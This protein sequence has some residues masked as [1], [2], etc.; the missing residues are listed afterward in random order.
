MV[1]TNIQILDYMN[2]KKSLMILII[3]N[4][5]ICF[6][7]TLISDSHTG[8][9]MRMDYDK[10]YLE[11]TN[12]GIG[13]PADMSDLRVGDKIIQINGQNVSELSDPEEFLKN[14][15]DQW[16][17]LSIKR[18]GIKDSLILNVPR[19]SIDLN[20]GNYWTEGNLFISLDIRQKAVKMP[21][22]YDLEKNK[23]E[24]IAIINDT[25]DPSLY[26]V[27]D[28][29]GGAGCDY[30]LMADCWQNGII[31]MLSDDSRNMELYKTFDFDFLS[32]DDPLMEKRL[33]A[34]LEARLTTLGLKRSQETPDILIILSF[35]SGQKDQFVPP[36]QIIS[37]KIKSVFSWYWGNIP[38]PVTESKTQEAYTQMTYL[39][40]INLKFLDAKE[41]ET[42]KTPPIIWAG[43]M[44]QISFE[45]I[46][47]TD[48][49]D[50]FFQMTM[51]Q[52]PLV[53][54]L[55]AEK[56]LFNNYAYTGIM[57]EQGNFE[58]VADVI[59]GSPAAIAG[60]QKGDKISNI[61]KRNANFS[62][63]PV[64][65]TWN[66]AFGYLYVY[67]KFKDGVKPLFPGVSGQFERFKENGVA[68]IEFDIKRNGKKLSF[69]IKPENKT[70]LVFDSYGTTLN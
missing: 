58:M 21:T 32:N 35:Y 48:Q 15:T 59:P 17:K 16:L 12:F 66:E 53:W 55:N 8:M 26:Q 29:F 23:N 9:K 10:K 45:K 40:N 18:I 19:V 14:N 11:V 20:S 64:L 28:V 7:Q 36:Q 27:Y 2:K 30:R 51:S 57:Y 47:L 44:S 1:F 69:N 3:L 62:G 52:F 49:A 70:A 43:S 50:E 54:Q 46:F 68:N 22:G 60:I 63:N 56:Y 61:N 31:T 67:T 33:A 39:S 37:T 24:L 41:I 65:G 6:S 4:F 5:G 13:T 25:P 38:V 34:M 42:S